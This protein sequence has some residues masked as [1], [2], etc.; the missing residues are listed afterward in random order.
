MTLETFKM[1]AISVLTHP[2]LLTVC[3]RR[4][5]SEERNSQLRSI[6]VRADDLSLSYKIT[7]DML[8]EHN[9]QLDNM[10]H[11]FEIPDFTQ[12]LSSALVIER[13]LKHMD[14]MVTR[15]GK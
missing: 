10:R 9:G 3:V 1:E 11:A 4:L 5:L 15:S 13:C 12:G 7:I 14:D 2:G 6:N 8:L